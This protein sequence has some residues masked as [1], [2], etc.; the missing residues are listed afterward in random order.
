MS[1]KNGAIET[2]RSGVA[3]DGAAPRR[4]WRD[5]R[6]MSRPMT[7]SETRRAKDEAAM[8]MVC[9]ARRE[10]VTATFEDVKARL[11]L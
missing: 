11:G 7:A 1:A 8:R 9:A 2:R 3:C 4:Q 10:P 6:S 5:S